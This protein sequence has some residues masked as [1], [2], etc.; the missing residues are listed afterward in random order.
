[1]SKLFTRPWIGVLTIIL[2]FVIEAIFLF[3]NSFLQGFPNHNGIPIII[4][5]ILFLFLIILSWVIDYKKY[6]NP[7]WSTI[8]GICGVSLGI[9][10][11]R[12]DWVVLL[13]LG[14]LIF[15]ILLIISFLNGRNKGVIRNEDGI[16][17][18]DARYIPPQVKRAV[19]RRDG[20]R[21]VL[22]GSKRQ[23]EYDHNIP[24]SKGGSNTENNIRILCKEC[25][26]RK[27]ARIE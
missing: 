8:W 10:V 1:M 9:I 5:Q 7:F 23:L 12:I 25:N 24:Y 22:C 6:K 18:D 21:C 19:W 26:R 14:I 15:S 27:S 2:L 20:G 11:V 17:S 3:V 13:V 16:P 4:L